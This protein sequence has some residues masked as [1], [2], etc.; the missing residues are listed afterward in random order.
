MRNGFT[1]EW[2]KAAMIRAIRTL[3]QAAASA[4]LVAIGNAQTIGEVNWKIVAS[5]AGLAAVVSL[6]TSM[7]TKLPEVPSDEDDNLNYAF[8]EDPDGEKL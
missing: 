6:L 3:V 8:K 2:A 7:V 4:A 1:S 5:T